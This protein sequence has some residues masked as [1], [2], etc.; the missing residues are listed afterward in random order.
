MV[1]SKR[2]MG[3][4]FATHLVEAGHNIRTVEELLGHKD[5]KTTMIHTHV[6]NWGPVGVRR[7]ADGL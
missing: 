5:V 3:D 6:V 1:V 7:R 4:F 2:H